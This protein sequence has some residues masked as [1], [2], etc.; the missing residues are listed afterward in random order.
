MLQLVPH[1]LASMSMCSWASGAEF[2]T[3]NVNV[4]DC[5]VSKLTGDADTELMVK[6]VV[7]Y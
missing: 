4:V 6:G 1:K 2:V 5:P 7:I 3:F